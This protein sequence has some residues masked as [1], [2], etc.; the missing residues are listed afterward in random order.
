MR[1]GPIAFLIGTVGGWTL[2]RAVM[3][4]PQAAAPKVVPRDI[5]WQPPLP[6]APQVTQNVQTPAPPIETPRSVMTSAVPHRLPVPKTAVRAAAAPPVFIPPGVP[7]S[8]PTRDAVAALGDAPRRSESRFS[9]STWAI[10]REGAGG[11]GLAAG[12][13]L[14]GSQAGFRAR[15]DFGGGVAVAVRVSGPLRSRQGKEA[16]VALDWRPAPAL[17]VTLTVERRAGLD[18]GGRDAFAAGLFGGFDAIALPFEARLDAYAQAG[19]VDLKRRD[20]YIDGAVRAE[21]RLIMRDGVSLAAGAGVW[22]G[23]QP[24]VARLDIGPQIVA[25]TPLGSGSIRVGAEW[26]QRVAGRARPGSGPVL[27]IGTSF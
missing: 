15:Y 4:W 12:G 20:A 14:A 10:L 21:R 8:R 9:L 19:V 3:L 16:A 25:R 22:G 26:R 23:A 11:N 7:G 27:S 18:R 6:S 2:I 1:L 17:P 24:G 13:Q 5:A